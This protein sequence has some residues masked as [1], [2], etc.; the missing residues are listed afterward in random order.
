MDDYT[1]FSQICRIVSPI[2]GVVVIL[3]TMSDLIINGFNWFK[4]LSDMGFGLIIEVCGTL[5]GFGMLRWV[6]YSVYKEQK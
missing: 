3:A 6:E 5:F 2:L 1:S 4:L